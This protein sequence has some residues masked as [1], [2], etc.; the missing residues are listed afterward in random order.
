VRRGF[1]LSDAPGLSRGMSDKLKFVEQ[2]DKDQRETPP[3]KAVASVTHQA[4]QLAAQREVYPRTSR[5]H[6]EVSFHTLSEAAVVSIQDG[7]PVGR[8]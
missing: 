7:P 2:A 1:A 5:G 3:H 6:P 8:T 4:L